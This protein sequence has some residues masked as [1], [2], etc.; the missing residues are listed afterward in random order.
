MEILLIGGTGT[1]SSAVRDAL[2]EDPTNIITILNRGKRPLPEHPQIKS[3]IADINDSNACEQALK[4]TRFDCVIHFVCFTQ[5]QAEASIR[6]FHDKTSQFIFISTVAT[7][8]HELNCI[9]NE[10]SPLGNRFSL[11]GQNKAAAEACFLEASRQKGFPLTII[12][13]SQ[14]YSEDRIPLSIKGRNCWSVIDRMLKGKPV[15]IHGD[16]QSVWASTHANDFAKG[17]CGLVGNR[18]ALGQIFHIMNPMNHTWDQVY[19]ILADLLGVDYRAVHIPSRLLSNSKSYDHLTAIQGDKMFSCIYD[20]SKIKRLVPGFNPKIGL[21]AG[22]KAYL[23]FMDLH[24]ELKRPDPD[25][26]DW[27][28]TLIGRYEKATENLFLD[29]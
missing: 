1:I 28:D 8:N 16:G 22:L 9:L 26:D 20:I 6:L 5:E 17:L 15:I 13:P 7:L 2:L 24:P 29:L 10:E 27:C 23:E 19:D 4:N 11:Y 25:F 18:D 21:E 3:L 14:T 12:R